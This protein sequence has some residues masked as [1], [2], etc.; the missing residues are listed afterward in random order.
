M[1]DTSN[2][3]VAQMK[4][5]KALA[6]SPVFLVV[7]LASPA[8]QALHTLETDKAVYLPGETALVTY[9][10][11]NTLD[12]P[13]TM[14]CRSDPDWQIVVYH[15][16]GDVTM[17][18]LLTGQE[19]VDHLVHGWA[20]VIWELY[21]E[22]GE[23]YSRQILWHLTDDDGRLL[24]PDPYTLVWMPL[25]MSRRL[26]LAPDPYLSETVN[27]LHTDIVIAPEGGVIAPE[28]GTM[29]MILVPAVAAV[30]KGNRRR[31]AQFSPC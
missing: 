13:F 5:H 30:M 23:S 11:L 3:G 6:W 2:K 22:P 31:R 18:Q 12:W 17:Y 7:L 8:A 9:T 14:E 19:P 16:P 10:L 15:N 1:V 27:P 25:S 20:W 4:S 21:L 26:P 24:E 29:A 28:P